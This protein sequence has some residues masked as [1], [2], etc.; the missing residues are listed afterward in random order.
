[1]KSGRTFA[2]RVGVDL[3]VRPAVALS[4]RSAVLPLALAVC[5]LASACTLER[6]SVEHPV[7]DSLASAFNPGLVVGA[8]DAPA[9]TGP[10]VEVDSLM[11]TFG[12]RDIPEADVI[13]RIRLAKRWGEEIFVL[14]DQLTTVHV[15]NLRTQSHVRVGRP[16]QGPGELAIPLGLAL[17]G[18]RMYV[19]DERQAIRVFARAEGEWSWAR[20]IP[21]PFLPLDICSMDD[22]LYVLAVGEKTS[23]VIHRLEQDQVAASFG[24]PYR[25]NDTFI[26]YTAAEGRL[27]CLPEVDGIAWVPMRLGEIHL[28]GTDGALRWIARLPNHKPMGIVE[29]FE[30]GSVSLGL[31]PG[32]TEMHMLHA[33]APLASNLLV[34][35][36]LYDR[37]A[38]E[39][40]APKAI[41]SYLLDVTSGAVREIESP[42]HGLIELAEG[43]M[44]LFANHPW[45]KVEVFAVSEAR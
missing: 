8:R 36:S 10:G 24:V 35:L 14:D 38:V 37:D 9:P 28:Y 3:P 17:S 26:R 12:A 23:A 18:D 21:V 41:Q 13:G 32:V 15:L 6:P 29:N 33:V 43:Q 31:T 25:W 30:S 19:A 5:S 27:A 16:G 20:D 7:P 1:M 4:R 39:A 45:P 34:Q 44:A 11:V 22:G 2:T 40:D 42:Y